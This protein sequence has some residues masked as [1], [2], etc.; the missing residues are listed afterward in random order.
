MISSIIKLKLTIIRTE[1]IKNKYFVKR[2]VVRDIGKVSQEDMLPLLISDFIVLI[3]RVIAKT[4]IVNQPTK[5]NITIGATD[6]APFLDEL[7]LPCPPGY[8]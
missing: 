3:T 7:E 5:P 8:T 1:K 2:I 4:E 6:Q